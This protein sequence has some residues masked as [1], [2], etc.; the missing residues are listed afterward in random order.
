MQ[1]ITYY[2]GFN[3][4][5]KCRN[6]QY[7]EGETFKEDVKLNL[8]S[9]G[10]HY[11]TNL[12]D[13][14]TYYPNKNDNK[15]AI[16]EPLGETLNGSNKN[17][18]NELK[19]V[20]VLSE[21]EIKEILKIEIAEYNIKNVF[22]VDIIL[23]LQSRYNITIGGSVSLFLN[24]LELDRKS[25]SIDLDVVMPYY[26]KMRT[27]DFGKDSIID[28]I[29][30]V[31]AKKSGNDFMYTFCVTSKDGRFLK[32]DVRISPEQSYDIITFK[33][34]EFKTCKVLETLAAKC[35]YAIEGNDKHKNDIFNLINFNTKT[36]NGKP[37]KDFDIFDCLPF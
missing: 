20:K 29:E 28:E 25:G 8:C 4:D 37:K 6:Y 36:N 1:K 16:V 14:F 17:C 27:K 30:E 19:I 15:F 12:K 24:G 34:Q 26:Q 32:V 9:R 35:K 21:K 10:F 3:K 2:K 13:T 7:K 33:D 5:L 11:C 18:T 23:E 31:D 22:C